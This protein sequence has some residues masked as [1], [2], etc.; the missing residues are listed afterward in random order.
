[1]ANFGYKG[2][3]YNKNFDICLLNTAI[4]KA[5]IIDKKHQIAACSPNPILLK[6]N[7]N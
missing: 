2:C 6:N 4:G 5:I 1:M 7:I 3:H